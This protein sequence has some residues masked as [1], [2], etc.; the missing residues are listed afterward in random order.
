[1]AGRGSL[2]RG[3]VRRIGLALLA[4]ATCASPDAP[5]RV[6]RESA[7]PARGVAAH[8]GASASHP[9]NTVAALREAARL[10]AH[11]IE[12]DVRA[13]RDR[14]LVVIHDATLDRTTD[15][16]G[17][18]A[19][20]DLEAIRRLDAGS[21]KHS[22]FAGERVPTLDEAL[23]AVPRDVWLN[24]HVKGDAWIAAAVARRLREAD[25]LHQGVI[26]SGAAGVA[27]ARAE[28]PEVWICSLDRGRTR[29]GYL[30]RAASQQADFVQLQ[31]RRGLPRPAQV[32]RARGAGLRL[33][34]CCASDPETV[35]RLFEAGVDFPLVDD[36]AM[37]LE[38]A[39]T[40]G[41]PPAR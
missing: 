28:V 14:E 33:N 1:M 24:I 23:A 22:R 17:A 36:L 39:R 35:L 4:L 9:E 26:A 12:F 38:V 18:V 6:P 2:S 31:Q 20:Q 41:I 11:Q 25:R 21:W 13:T 3:P 15:G 8:R 27:A 29:R 34:V 16:A 30:R 32:E 19:E 7:L 5:P 10:G 37:G 40:L